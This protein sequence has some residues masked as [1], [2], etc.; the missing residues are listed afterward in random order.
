MKCPRFGIRIALAFLGFSIPGLATSSAL[1]AQGSLPA[2]SLPANSLPASPLP[3]LS[4]PRPQAYP[5][6]AY[7]NP[8]YP[9]PAYYPA[10]EPPVSM[11]MSGLLS[12]YQAS[13]D[14]DR[15]KQI[16]ET[17]TQLVQKQFDQTHSMQQ[18]EIKTLE[19]LLAQKKKRIEKRE[20]IKDKIVTD[21]V[22]ALVQKAEGTGWESDGQPF[23]SGYALPAI[24]PASPPVSLTPLGPVPFG[25]GGSG[26]TSGA[27]VL[28]G[29]QTAGLP[30][31]FELPSQTAG[32]YPRA[33]VSYE[34]FK[35]LVAEVEPHRSA[36]ILSLDQFLQMSKQP[37]V[38]VLDTRSAFRYE[39][40]HIQG[41][42]HLSFTDFTQANLA[43]VIPTPETTVLIYCNNNFDGNQIDFA[44]KSAPSRPSS[45]RSLGS[46]V[47]SQEKPVQLALNVPTYINLYGY[48]Y[49]NVYELGELVKVTDP[50]IQFEGT[51]VGK[52]K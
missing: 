33:R 2:S 19:A 31:P 23:P 11:L 5:N 17:I 35:E 16:V 42:K 26:P 38:M 51:M 13:Q 4:P 1:L 32:E 49:Q 29:A 14:E 15:K 52:D 24:P 47:A 39:R 6:P 7:D 9:M 41:A 34:D 3:A 30:N 50:R 43:G 48:G 21:R 8:A 44:S 20:A 10:S 45:N 18:Q 40:I 46:Q 27:Q 22:A 25:Q 28:F 36:R 37:N 12:E